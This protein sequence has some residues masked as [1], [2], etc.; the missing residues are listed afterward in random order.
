MHKLFVSML[1][2]LALAGCATFNNPVSLTTQY[3]IEA[4]YLAAENI[5][6]VYMALPLCRTGTV[7]TLS[8]PCGRR[9]IDVQI[10]KTGAKAQA[11]VVALRN[12]TKNNPTL[13][14]VTA[15]AA[16][17]AALSDSQFAVSATQRTAQ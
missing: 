7:S 9:S 3:D 1:F 8:S 6:L 15:I 4:G 17:Q 16:A 5:A 2:A 13:N 12:F 10:Q 11:A 14:P